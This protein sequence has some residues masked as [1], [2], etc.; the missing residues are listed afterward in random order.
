MQACHTDLHAHRQFSYDD[1]TACRNFGGEFRITLPEG[2]IQSREMAKTTEVA[3]GTVRPVLL[4]SSADQE[5]GRS[6]S[7]ESDLRQISAGRERSEGV[8]R[9]RKGG[10]GS[11][12]GHGADAAGVV[13][14]NFH[15]WD[16]RVDIT[17]YQDV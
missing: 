13:D 5:G 6:R 3:V 9:G 11:F 10:A 2:T 12:T 7:S 1:G 8:H 15:R 17:L 16:L 14:D 4:K